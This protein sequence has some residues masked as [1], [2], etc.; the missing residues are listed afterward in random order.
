MDDNKSEK[1]FDIMVDVNQLLNEKPPSIYQGKTPA[2]RKFF[3]SWAR[4]T[5]EQDYLKTLVDYRLSV[6]AFGILK[7]APLRRGQ[8]AEVDIFLKGVAYGVEMLYGDIKQASTKQ[9]VTKED[10]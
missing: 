10:K 6:V 9:E 8:D 3:Q 1:S 4:R 5:L 2:W 7:Q